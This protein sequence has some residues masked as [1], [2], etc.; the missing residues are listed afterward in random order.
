M[1]GGLSIWFGISNTCG[2][3]QSNRVGQI[4]ETDKEHDENCVEER[5]QLDNKKFDSNGEGVRQ[6]L[7]M[8]NCSINIWDQ[9]VLE[10]ALCKKSS[11]CLEN[12][13]TIIYYMVF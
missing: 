13:F 7:S 1:F 10:L 8:G 2:G 5:I 12:N 4:R 3:V 6:A 9:S 11:S